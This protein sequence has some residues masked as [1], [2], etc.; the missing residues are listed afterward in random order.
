MQYARK[1]VR[2][3]VGPPPADPLPFHEDLRRVSP[4]T[5][6]QGCCRLPTPAAGNSRTL[7]DGARATEV[8]DAA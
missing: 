1:L 5:E 4:R 6:L 2:A 7:A 8:A 3:S